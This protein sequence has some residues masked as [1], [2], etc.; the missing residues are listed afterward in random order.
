MSVLSVVRLCDRLMS[1]MFFSRNC[2]GSAYAD[3]ITFD[4]E[5]ICPI[6]L[7]KGTNTGHRSEK[8]KL[9]FPPSS[10]GVLLL[11]TGSGMDL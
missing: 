4:G 5:N 7:T 2:K 11:P 6:P 3:A 8:G 1:E 10:V 9:Q